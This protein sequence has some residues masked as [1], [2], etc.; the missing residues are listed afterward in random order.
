MRV[1]AKALGPFAFADERNACLVQDASAFEY[2]MHRAVAN[3]GKS[4]TN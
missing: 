4:H 3:A 2:V 1:A